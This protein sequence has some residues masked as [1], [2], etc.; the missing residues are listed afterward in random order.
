MLFLQCTKN[1]ADELKIKLN[2]VPEIGFDHK[3]H[4]MLTD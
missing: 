1:L 4:G 3:F 2:S